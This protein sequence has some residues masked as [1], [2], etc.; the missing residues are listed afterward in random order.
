MFHYILATRRRSLHLK[1]IKIL[2]CLTI[3]HIILVPQNKVSHIGQC[4]FHSNGL[5]NI[6]SWP[7]CVS[8]Y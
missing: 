2:S 6:T 5:G 7:R 1:E 3:G 4:K 8:N